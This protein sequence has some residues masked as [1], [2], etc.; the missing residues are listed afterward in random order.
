MKDYLIGIKG[1]G[2]SAL[3][4]L[5]YDL[6]NEVVG[7][8]DSTDIKFTLDGLKKRGIEVYHDDTFKPSIDFIVCFSNAI[9]ENHKEIVRLKKLGLKMIRYQDLIGSLT[10]EFETI[11]VSGTHG[12]TTT[13]LMLS[14]IL[15]KEV[16]CNYFVGDG[17]G[18][19]DK[20]NKYNPLFLLLSLSLPY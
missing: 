18:H 10:K 3:A 17:R 2:M 1:S 16:G 15:D 5:L 20:K 14:S 9:N 11:S 6:G 8:D 13:S 4:G 7:Y 19:G 12:K